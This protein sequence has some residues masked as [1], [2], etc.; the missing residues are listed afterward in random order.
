[1]SSEITV[2]GVTTAE[3]SELKRA[4]RGNTGVD[5]VE[6]N[7]ETVELVG[8]QEGLRELDRTLWVREL[9]ANQYGQPSL[10]S[11]DRS[12]RTQLRKAV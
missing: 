2:E 10:A 4:V 7:A 12:V 5:I 8:E 3:V 1:M 9:A 6:A 11:V